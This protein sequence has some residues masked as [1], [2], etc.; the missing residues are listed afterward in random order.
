MVPA[1]LSCAGFLL[2]RYG[3]SLF[4]SFFLGGFECSTHRRHDGRRLD[5]I[6]SSQHQRWARQDYERLHHHGI[7][8]ARDGVRWHL[9]D[10]GGSYDWSSVLPMI[11]AA[12][13]TGTQII[14]DILHYGYPDNLDIWRPAFV[15]RFARFVRAFARLLREETDEV[16]F[17]TP[18]NEL[19]FFSWAA[20]DVGYLNPFEGGRG[21]ELKAQLVRCALAAA[22]AIW[23][24][25]G[26]ARLM[27][28]DP[29]I[30]IVPDFMRPDD[31]PHVEARRMAQYQAWDMLRGEV[32]PLLGGDA[33]YLD[34]VGVNYYFN[35]Q[36]IDGG[37]HVDADHPH[38]RPLRDM[39][40]EA[41][42]RFQRP[43]LIAETGIEFERRPAWLRYV[44]EEARAAMDAGVALE[45]ICLYPVVNH[46]GW[47]DD[48]H[49]H[50]GLFDYADEHG[51]RPVYAPLADELARQQELFAPY[52]LEPAL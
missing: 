4:Q 50:N 31:A 5:V 34:I 49:C 3:M 45:G 26:R 40:I 12:R 41:Y 28:C 18:V 19:S 43:L 6:A 14:W 20:G 38:Y 32:W 10:R 44:G 16:P 29:L 35:N 39:L 51:H 24:V 8:A 36:W 15:E 47:D 17:F 2:G 52:A 48:R 7:G 21:F 22:D 46:P 30:H 11:H 33:R 1:G 13:D 25:D 37:P 23:S 9:I 42:R 27:H